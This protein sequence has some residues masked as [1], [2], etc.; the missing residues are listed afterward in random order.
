MGIVLV[1]PVKFDARNVRGRKRHHAPLSALQFNFS[2]FDKAL[3]G[4]LQNK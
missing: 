3:C 4:A 1:S 2:E